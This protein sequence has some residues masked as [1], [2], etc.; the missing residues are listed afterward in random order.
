LAVTENPDSGKYG[1]VLVDPKGHVTGFS[2]R[3]SGEASWHFVGVQVVEAEAF[4]TVPP[5]TPFE[6]TRQLYPALFAEC[7][8]S[9]RAHVCRAE[10]FDIGT[11]GDYLRT[12]LLLA[13]REASGPS[14][15]RG[16]RID[17]SARIDASVLWDDVAVGADVR[18]TRCVLTDG[19]HVPAGSAWTETI[20][21]PA[22][23]ELGSAERQVG[24]LY[25]SP[26]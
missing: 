10:F 3:G 16:G 8:T 11:P 9:V 15:G 24:D 23:G 5:G 20:L 13:G 19:V 18:L 26:L 25:V 4:R 7:P 6:S 17:P 1:G 12:S 14:V 2:R 22:R 21:R